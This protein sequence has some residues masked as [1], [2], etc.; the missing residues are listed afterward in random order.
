MKQTA[1]ITGASKRI[2][3]AIALYLAENGWNIAVHFNTSYPEADELVKSL[4]VKYNSQIFR[5]FRA[6][7]KKPEEVESL[8]PSV[9]QAFGGIDLLHH[10]CKK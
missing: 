3:K 9:L 7:L 4:A 10:V 6:D 8:I 1:L 5:A 2:G